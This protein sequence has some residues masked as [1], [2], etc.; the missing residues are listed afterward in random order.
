[1]NKDGLL[2]VKGHIFSKG[3]QLYGTVRGYRHYPQ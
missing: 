3:C 1:M 2:L